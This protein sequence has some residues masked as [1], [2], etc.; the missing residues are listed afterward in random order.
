MCD[1]A[2][3]AQLSSDD[4]LTRMLGMCPH[5]GRTL[6]SGPR[7]VLPHTLFFGVRK[8]NPDCIY[9]LAALCAADRFSATGHAST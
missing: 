1:A 3:V 5:V 9:A 2:P 7:P 6:L 8:T 4:A